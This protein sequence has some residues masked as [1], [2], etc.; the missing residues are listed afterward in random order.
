MAQ[1]RTSEATTKERSIPPKRSLKTVSVLSS[2]TSGLQSPN[3]S[4]EL[5]FNFRE[6]IRN[7]R[8]RPTS[9]EKAKSRDPIER[10]LANPGEFYIEKPVS[11]FALKPGMTLKDLEGVNF[12]IT[13]A[14]KHT[15]NKYTVKLRSGLVT[16]VP[17]HSKTSAGACGGFAQQITQ[18]HFPEAGK[19][20]EGGSATDMARNLKGA[21]GWVLI[22][23]SLADID[24]YLVGQNPKKGQGLKNYFPD[25]TQIYYAHAYNKHPWGHVQNFYNAVDA[26]GKRKLLSISDFNQPSVSGEADVKNLDVYKRYRR[27]GHNRSVLIAIPIKAGEGATIGEPLNNQEV[28][29]MLVSLTTGNTGLSTLKKLDSRSQ[30][31]V[32]KRLVNAVGWLNNTL[33]D[34]GKISES[35]HRDVDKLLKISKSGGLSQ[36]QEKAIHQLGVALAPDKPNL[37]AQNA[38]AVLGRLMMTEHK[39]SA[40]F[41]SIA[42]SLPRGQQYVTDVL[43]YAG[44]LVSKN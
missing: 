5:A 8:R 16:R 6:W 34:R 10:Q 15:K 26:N 31:L 33:R 13:D 42:N 35:V 32:A 36:E 2:N 40:H 1:N 19:H 41:R 23:T 9:Q 18:K 17:L 29:K 12:P 28:T 39:N 22:K 43:K 14:L 21:P 44:Q 38:L 30:G 20:I 37:G 7:N 3:G 4:K 25:G 27:G 11:N 24:K